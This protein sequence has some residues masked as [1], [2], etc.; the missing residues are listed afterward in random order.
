MTCRITQCIAV[1][2]FTAALVSVGCEG[3]LPGLTGLPSTT[4]SLGDLVEGSGIDTVVFSVVNETPYKIKLDITVDGVAQRIECA[5]GQ[6]CQATPATCPTA[7]TTVFEQW[8][9]DRGRV[10]GSRD[11]SNTDAFDFPAGSFTCGQVLIWR[12]NTA[13]VNT[14]VL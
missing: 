6:V 5:A 9:D 11:Y 12:L 10:V 2:S 4:A 1:L 8:V 3:F 14:F 13:Y 7:V